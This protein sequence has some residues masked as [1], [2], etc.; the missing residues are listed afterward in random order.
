MAEMIRMQQLLPKFEYCGKLKSKG[1]VAFEWKDLDFPRIISA[2]T[3]PHGKK[4]SK[5]FCSDLYNLMEPLYIVVLH[6][7]IGQIRELK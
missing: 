1:E 3:K 4:E 5:F 7:P 6:E 2:A